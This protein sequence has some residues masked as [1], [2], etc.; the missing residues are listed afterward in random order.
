MLNIKS[1]FTLAT[2]IGVTTAGMLGITA[3]VLASS[4][5]ERPV[6]LVVPYPPGGSSD[7][8]ARLIAR[9]MG[10]RLGQPFIVENRPGANAIIGTQAVANSKPDGYTI[11]HCVSTAFLMNPHLYKINYD[12][13]KDFQPI[14]LT[15]AV[16]L[17]LATNPSI[18]AKSVDDF[19]KYAKDNP[20]KVAYSTYG[21]GSLA[22]I[23]GEI[24]TQISK[25][26]LLHIPFKG[27]AAAVQDTIAGRTVATF[28]TIPVA[29]PHVKSGSLT[30]VA[31]TSSDPVP[32]LDV[33]S[34][35][36]QGYDLVVN[37][38]N[39]LCA[40]SGIPDDVL[41]KLH[42]TIVASLKDPEF[43]ARL[44]DMGYLVS[45]SPTPADFSASIA[46]DLVVYGNIIKS[47]N[48]KLN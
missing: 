28:T 16:P 26:D 14:S 8:L 5:P 20:D 31:V 29:M 30:A 32:G 22:H 17:M 7:T 23:A 21:Q 9:E 35:V 24:L 10:D 38:W 18:N 40:P 12:P 27:S 36:N 33:P 6:T 39:G 34:F 37:G 2:V 25:T 41:T 46:R 45:W 13:I 15:A 19:I 42:D 43:N 11:L 47:A 48:I 4:Y 1:T 3:S 44:T